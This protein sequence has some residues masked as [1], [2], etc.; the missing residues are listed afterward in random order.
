MR[1][2]VSRWEIK[3]SR[4]IKELWDLEVRKAP[5]IDWLELEPYIV[6][7]NGSEEQYQYCDGKLYLDEKNN[8][9]CNKEIE[10]HQKVMK[11]MSDEGK[12]EEEIREYMKGKGT[13]YI[14][15][16]EWIIECKWL[17]DKIKLLVSYL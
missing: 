9:L 13:D 8:E 3:K 12:T 10:E 4:F 1:K 5:V 7:I 15:R 17:S 2:V 14:D 6:R 16:V 11:L